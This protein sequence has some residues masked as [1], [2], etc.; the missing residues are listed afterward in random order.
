MK[1]EVI[2]DCVIAGSRH[3]VGDILEIDAG[4][5]NDLMGIGRIMP[6]DESKIENRSIGLGEDKPR[7]RAKKAEPK[8][9]AETEVES[10][11]E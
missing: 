2:R 4:L 11:E 6:A 8:V 1:Y 7:R 3:K 9:E 5:A 10:G